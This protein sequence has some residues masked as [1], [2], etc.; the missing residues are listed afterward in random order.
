MDQELTKKIEELELKINDI[1]KTLVTAKN[2]FKWSMIISLLLFVIP[3]II[4]MFILPS[5]IDTMTASYSG[6]L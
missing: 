3:L 2:I 4:L 1:H 6:L 5:M